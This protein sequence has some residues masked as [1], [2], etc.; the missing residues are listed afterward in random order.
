MRK[1]RSCDLAN[2]PKFGPNR[3]PSSTTRQMSQDFS[4]CFQS[5][6]SKSLLCFPLQ[7]LYLPSPDSME[8]RQAM[9]AVP[10][11]TSQHLG[12]RAIT[13]SLF[14]ITK[15]GGGGG[16]WGGSDSNQNIISL[17]LLLGA[18]PCPLSCPLP[19]PAPCQALTFQ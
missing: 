7:S 8:P 11:Q 18:A 12:S 15:L 2:S 3:Q 17:H 19:L 6:A 10:C 1:P 16:L 13:K 5:P 9:P 4:R 14:Y